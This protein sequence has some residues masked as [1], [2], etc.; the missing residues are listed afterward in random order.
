MKQRVI[1]GFFFTIGIAA[2]IIP[3][4]FIHWMPVLLFVFVALM[5]SYE[6]TKALNHK[7]LYPSRLVVMVGS[8][9]ALM[10]ILATGLTAAAPTR[11]NYGHELAVGTSLLCF[12]LLSLM[13]IHVI[14]PVIRHNPE[15]L[16][17]GVAG[18]ALIGYV[19][20][21][22]GCSVLLLFNIPQ[23]WFWLVMAL[24]TPWISD[25]AAY[26]IGS[27]FGRH[28]IVP[29]ISPKKTIE[30]CL[31]G[32]V[33]TMLLLAVYFHFVLRLQPDMSRAVQPNTLFALAAG[34][35]LSVSSQL[36][37]WLAS[38]IKR[39]CGIKDFGKILPGH[40]GLMD[41][42]DSAFF[43]MPVS[44]FLAIIYLQLV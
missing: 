21:P 26:F 27:I 29:H 36:G 33:G 18:S 8:L 37:D 10:P 5:S 28:T 35:V 25:T 19:A 1:T 42:F 15:Y 2:F 22:L 31:G 41:R 12:S 4:L 9:L 39:W 16:P 11:D 44:L 13:T 24:A 6:L 32:I 3:G 38:A 40:G 17:T 23:G 30:G 20:F 43:T 14:L 7:N 34:L